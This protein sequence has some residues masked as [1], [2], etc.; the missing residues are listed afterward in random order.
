VRTRSLKSRD[1]KKSIDESRPLDEGRS[2]DEKR[3]RADDGCVDKSRMVCGGDCAF[4]KRELG[5]FRT[6]VTSVI[7]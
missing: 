4:Y 7:R 6:R 2:A 5:S 1:E 3:S